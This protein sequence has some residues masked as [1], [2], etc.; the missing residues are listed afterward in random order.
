MLRYLRYVAVLAVAGA[1][2]AGLTL[3]WPSASRAAIREAVRPAAVAHGASAPTSTWHVLL[4]IF[5]N[6][7]TDYVDS[8]GVTRHL[9]ASIPQS[10]IDA[11]VTAMSGAVVPAVRQWSDDQAVWDVDVRYPSQPITSVATVD[12]TDEEQWVSPSCLSDAL[13]QYATP[14]YYDNVMVY[15][16]NSDGAGDS[17]PAGGSWGLTLGDF[18][19]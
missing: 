1:L 5:R 7:D 13:Q 9:T 8:L 6:T 3:A 11:L 4:L 14:G 15:W 12:P 16:A 17:I 19:N 10:D 2:A 18:A